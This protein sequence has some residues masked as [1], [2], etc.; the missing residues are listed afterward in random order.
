MND[1]YAL[2][3]VSGDGLIGSWCHRLAADM[4][5]PVL[6]S[7]RRPDAQDRL[8]IDL[9][10]SNPLPDDPR[11]QNL[12][13]ALLLAAE[14]NIAR[15]EQ[16]QTRSYQ[17]NVTGLLRLAQQLTDRGVRIIFASTDYVYP[18]GTGLYR[19]DQAGDPTTAYGRQKL[20]AEEGL[21]DITDDSALIL[22]LS[23]IYTLEHGDGSL[24]DEMA[25]KLARGEAV[26]AAVDQ[27]FCPLWIEDLVQLITILV[28]HGVH[29]P[30]NVCGDEA[31][32]RYKMALKL[33]LAM[34]VDPDLVQPIALDDLNLT[35][36]RPRNTSMSNTLMRKFVP[37]EQKSLMDINTAV[38]K[39]ALN[40]RSS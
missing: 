20:E 31:W 1:P 21:R 38:R 15:C 24:F 18:D 33:A 22:R 29:G 40:Y 25:A 30:I 23:K 10:D 3:L 5:I 4:D 34:G 9:E 32:P 39:I 35:P 26:K 17:V 28:R 7:S 11:L 14:A 36:A 27:V 19:E 16:D 12:G 6:A 8:H 13:N 37:P 2:L